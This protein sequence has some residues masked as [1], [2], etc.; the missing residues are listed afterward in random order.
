[1]IH[2]RLVQRYSEV[3]GLGAKGS[4]SSLTFSSRLTFMSLRWKTADTAF[5]SAELQL[6]NLEVFTYSCHVFAE[7][8]F[9]CLPLPISIH[10]CKIVSVMAM[11]MVYCS[12]DSANKQKHHKSHRMQ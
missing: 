2:E 9:H 7:H 10:D 11:V 1:M 4:V 5:V 3:F 6:P 8:S 12:Y